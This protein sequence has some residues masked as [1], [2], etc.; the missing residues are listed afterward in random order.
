MKRSN[1]HIDTHLFKDT[2]PGYHEYTKKCPFNKTREEYIPREVREEMGDEGE[3]G[4][5]V[6]RERG[7][8]EEECYYDYFVKSTYPTQE[9]VC[10]YVWVHYVCSIWVP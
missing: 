4:V 2:N 6:V 9:P 1:I 5:R 7:D 10:H 8:K 3:E